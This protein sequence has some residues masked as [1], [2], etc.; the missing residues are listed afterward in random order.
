MEAG[1]RRCRPAFSPAE[2]ENKKDMDMTGLASVSRICAAMALAALPAALV[3]DNL[4][5]Y[6]TFENGKADAMREI[7]D[8]NK[9]SEYSG[10]FDLF[11]EDGT[12]N[13]CLR[14][15]A[16]P[17]QKHKV[18][19]NTISGGGVIVSGDG[20]KGIPVEPGRFYDFSFELKGS[21]KRVLLN[22]VE[23]GTENGKKTS[24]TIESGLRFAPGKEWRSFKKRF[25]TGKTAER[26]ELHFVLWTY[27]GKPG[28]FSN[29]LFKPGDS[30]LIDNLSLL[31]DEQFPK[32]KAMLEKAREPFLVAPCAVE[33]DA[34]CP[35]LPPELLNPPEKI[36]LRAAVNE[37]KPLP[38]AI[39]NLTVSFAQ[40]RVTLEANQEGMDGEKPAVDTGIF[41]LAGYPEE[42]IAVFEALRFKDAESNPA[43]LRLDPLVDV[44]GASVISVPPK[45]SGA[46]WFD[47]DTYDVNPG[48]YRG[49]LHVIP[50][51]EGVRYRQ[52]GGAYSDMKP[53]EKVVP[54]EFTVDPIVLPRE[55]V[56]PSHMCSPCTRE[57]GFRLESD[58]GAR[59]YNLGTRFFTP[60]AVGNPQSDARK[61]IADHLGWAK[62][63]GTDITFFVKY[64]AL[65]VSQR[66]FNPKKD[67]KRKWEAWERYVHT[68][69]KVMEEAGVAFENYCV[70]LKDEPANVDLPELREA[71]QRL[72]RLYPRMQTYLSVCNRTAGEIDYMDYLGGMIDFWALH[73]NMFSAPGMLEKFR[74]AKAKY[75]AK[76]LHYTCS[77][78]MR[79]P[80]SAYYR[81]HCWRGE[82]MQLDAD[83]MFRFRRSANP[84]YG[85]LHYKVVPYGELVFSAG[86]RESPTVRYM[87]Y[88]EGM[89]DVKYLQAL[90]EK[91]G[92]EPEVAAFL[93]KAVERVVKDDPQS[94]SLPGEVRE[95]V[96]RMLLEG[97]GK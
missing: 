85:D 54:V 41:G 71:L 32:I 59:I 14:L 56:R 63:R 53:V 34:S 22:I 69:A 1:W 72:K 21:P 92:S 8:G 49:R 90:R 84:V 95:E 96:R 20:G 61:A 44:N 27:V 29:D 38:V 91:R 43:T 73:D 60:D 89:T 82:H 68:V 83:M 46:V 77:V 4:V 6:G 33:S 39:A 3:A 10:T 35:F 58:I 17:A 88:R 48:V 62:R 94:A 2:I 26:I 79:E 64:E 55:S 40:Y 19:G 76:L 57:E 81:R 18:S 67:P 86:G 97:A 50:L 15:T 45:E 23:Y 24:R 31:R 80:L 75:G 28:S 42:K 52:R 66:I 93:K 25:R 87:A 9:A 65:S 30:V 51:A 78:S 37:K 16:G 13:K 11:T 74:A 36:V 12:W 47:F 70:L 5:R 7:R